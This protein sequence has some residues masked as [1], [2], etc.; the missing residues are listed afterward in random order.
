[1]QDTSHYLDIELNFGMTIELD[2]KINENTETLILACLGSALYLNP[3]GFYH[4][5][6]RIAIYASCSEFTVARLW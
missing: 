3:L 1:M 5:T 6:W 4:R 2:T